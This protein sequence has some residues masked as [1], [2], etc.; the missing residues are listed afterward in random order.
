VIYGFLLS[1]LFQLSLHSLVRNRR[2]VGSALLHA[3][4]IARNDPFATTRAVLVDAVLYVTVLAVHG[5]VW[6]AWS[7][8]GEL[9]LLLL[10]PLSLCIEA[11]VGGTRCA[12]WSSAYEGL[13]GISTVDDQPG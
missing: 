5:V 10:V 3:W 4:R 12:Y 8:S 1:V 11:I 2:G 13:G 7:L 9:V 6:L